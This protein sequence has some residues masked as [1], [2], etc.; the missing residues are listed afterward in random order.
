MIARVPGLNSRLVATRDEARLLL[1]NS[2]FSIL[3]VLD[4]A[5]G[6]QRPV[7]TAH[8]V[9]GEADAMVALAWRRSE[10]RAL[11]FFAAEQSSVAR[12]E[13]WAAE[14]VIERD[15]RYEY[16]DAQTCTFSGEGPDFAVVGLKHQLKVIALPLEPR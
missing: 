9:R 14:G 16:P 13:S 3:S 2:H 10:K 1:A 5:T 7:F 6:A 15:W 11:I 12:I 8:E 4:P